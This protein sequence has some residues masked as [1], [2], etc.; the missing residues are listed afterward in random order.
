MLWQAMCMNQPFDGTNRRDARDA[1]GR[2]FNG[3]DRPCAAP[4]VRAQRVA[5]RDGERVE[6]WVRSTDLTGGPTA[7]WDDWS[8]PREAEARGS[9]GRA[10][11][12]L[13]CGSHRPGDRHR[14]RPAD[15]VGEP[16]AVP[17]ARWK[18]ANLP[19]ERALGAAEWLVLAA[20]SVPRNRR[21]RPTTEAG[22]QRPAEGC[23]RRWDHHRCDRA[24]VGARVDRFRAAAPV[25]AIGR[26]RCP[27]H[28]V[29]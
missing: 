28:R 3:N 20:G 15:Q 21:A 19:V 8:I 12:W 16:S 22:I 5:A 7:S 25:R 9:P 10:L 13:D 11:A 6:A 18:V 23:R 1:A 29:G 17:R 24:R 27:R 4:N 2:R 26:W 14:S